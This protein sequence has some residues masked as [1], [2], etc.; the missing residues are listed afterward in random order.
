MRH[1]IAMCIINLSAMAKLVCSVISGPANDDNT[2][3]FNRPVNMAYVSS[4]NIGTDAEEQR[5]FI[6]FEG[7][8]VRWWFATAQDMETVYGH[9]INQEF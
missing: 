2:N 1:D 6:D 5:Y 3:Y 9:I 7:A 4:L 8:S